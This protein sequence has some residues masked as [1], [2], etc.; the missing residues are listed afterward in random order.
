MICVLRMA[1]LICLLVF[2]GIGMACRNKLDQRREE[3][4]QLVTKLLA[5][6]LGQPV[7]T[8]LQNA[9]DNRVGEGDDKTA[10]VASGSMVL[11]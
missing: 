8:P 1:S 11:Q 9:R 5:F 2:A 3:C 6:R 4:R 7:A 10:R